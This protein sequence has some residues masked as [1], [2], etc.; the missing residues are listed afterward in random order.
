MHV[1]HDIEAFYEEITETVY[2]WFGTGINGEN[3]KEAINLVVLKHASPVITGILTPVKEEKSKKVKKED[4][5]VIPE[6]LSNSA[7]KE[8]L[9]DE[10]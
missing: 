9:G 6:V 8:T 5:G 1:I 3:G 10:I 2:H 4:L 7:E